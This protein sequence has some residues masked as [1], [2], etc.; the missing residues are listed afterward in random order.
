MQ[1]RSN[2][3]KTKGKFRCDNVGSYCAA[4]ACSFRPNAK[5]NRLLRFST[6]FVLSATPL[7]AFAFG[8]SG[9]GAESSTSSDSRA[10]A[11][12]RGT[13]ADARVLTL[14]VARPAAFPSPLPGG[15]VSAEQ[16]VEITM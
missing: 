12:L 13:E 1:I 9:A 2:A 5:L 16:L 15:V 7:R 14:R 8:M 4:V 11:V 10:E 6:A 3:R